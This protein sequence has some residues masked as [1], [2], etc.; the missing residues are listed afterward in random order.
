M[1]DELSSPPKKKKHKHIL[2][3]SHSHR[4]VREGQVALVQGGAGAF[5][6]QLDQVPAALHHAA[7][8]HRRVGLRVLQHVELAEVELHRADVGVLRMIGAEKKGVRIKE[9]RCRVRI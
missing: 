6:H 8:V 1:L 9:K 7:H 5:G 3:V 2:V 4:I